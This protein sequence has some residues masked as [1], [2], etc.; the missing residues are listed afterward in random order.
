MGGRDDRPSRRGRL[1][2]RQWARRSAEA[3]PLRPFTLR[4]RDP[5]DCASKWPAPRSAESSSFLG[6]AREYM[7][8]VCTADGFYGAGAGALAPATL[9]WEASAASCQVASCNR[10]PTAS[11]CIS[12]GSRRALLGARRAGPPDVPPE[13]TE[14]ARSGSDRTI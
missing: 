2:V 9:A 12:S 10:S 13:G 14:S 8:I 1:G 6:L 4:A 5:C 11:E 3:S 7:M